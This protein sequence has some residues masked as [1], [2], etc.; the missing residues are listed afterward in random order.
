MI[1]QI[2]PAV[3]WQLVDGQAVIVDIDTGRS[4]GL[5]STA[6]FLW[7]RLEELDLSALVST[8]ANEFSLE[9]AHAETSVRRLVDALLHRGLIRSKA[10]A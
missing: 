4:V 8:F 2:S 9:V 10:N 6:T 5:N 1:Y 3:A 7:S